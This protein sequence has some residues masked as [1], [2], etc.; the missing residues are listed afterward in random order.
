MKSIVAL[1][2]V[3]LAIVACEKKPAENTTTTTPVENVVLPIEYT[4]TGSPGVGTMKNVQVVA[5][6]SKRLS[7]LNP[8]VGDLLADTVH[9]SMSEGWELIAPRDSALAVLKGF[10]GTLTSM[11]IVY[12]SQIPIDNVDKKHEWVFSWSDETYTYK[13]GKTE[14]VFLHEDYRLENGKIKEVYQYAR[15]PVGATK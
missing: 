4:Y 6:F 7:E 5:E 11:K 8:D 15:K 3:A 12:T 2:A 1:V 10:L 9:W 14:H 13:D